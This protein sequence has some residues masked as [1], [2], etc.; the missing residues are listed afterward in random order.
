MIYLSSTPA[1]ITS[2]IANNNNSNTRRYEDSGSDWKPNA[3]EI[4]DA[5]RVIA[6]LK[7]NA[8]APCSNMTN[9]KSSE[10]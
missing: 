5:E 6:R 7:A 2:I 10:L 9:N 8:N 4:R 3:A 1:L